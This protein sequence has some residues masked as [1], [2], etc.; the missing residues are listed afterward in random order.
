MNTILHTLPRWLGMAAA[1]LLVACRHGM[2][3]HRWRRRTHLHPDGEGGLHQ[4]RRRQQRLFLGLCQWQWH[5]AVPRR[6]DDRQPGRRGHGHSQQR[7]A[8]ADL[9]R[10]PG[11]AGR[12]SGGGARLD[13][14]GSAGETGGVPGTVTYTF[15]AS[16]PGTYLYHS[17]TRPDLQ[18]E[19]GL[20]GALIVRPADA[21]Q[22]YRAR[23]HR[24]RPGVSVP[25]HG[26]GSEIHERVGSQ[27]RRVSRVSRSTW[28]WPP[29]VYNPV[30]WF[31]NGRSAGYRARANAPLLPT[32]PYDAMP[33]MHPG[34]SA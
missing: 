11:P 27:W 34:R 31:I 6:H 16:Q 12:S 15:V 7:T 25:A 8:R 14:A 29:N 28:T 13:D 10:L 2:G 1:L 21:N 17:G 33:R 26:D 22:A 5:D 30:Y 3:H 4:H 9:D 20:V 18:V 24:L 23:R 19:M 32:Q